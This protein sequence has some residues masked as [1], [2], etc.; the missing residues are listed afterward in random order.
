MKKEPSVKIM[1]S[2]KNNWTD[3]LGSLQDNEKWEWRGK[4]LV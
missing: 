4:L 1:R 3:F 2:R